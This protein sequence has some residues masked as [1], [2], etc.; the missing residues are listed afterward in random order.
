MT[1]PLIH[2]ALS[3][4]T[5]TLTDKIEAETD[6]EVLNAMQKAVNASDHEITMPELHAF[7]RRR[8]EL[9]KGTSK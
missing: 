2:R 8:A 5:I 3:G 1:H 4:E 7:A 9:Q 6:L